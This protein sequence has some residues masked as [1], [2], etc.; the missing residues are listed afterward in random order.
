MFWCISLRKKSMTAVLLEKV[1][2]HLKF[3]MWRILNGSCR[4]CQYFPI[5]VLWNPRIPQNIVR[6]S[7]RNC[8]INKNLIPLRIQ[9]SISIPQEFL[10]SNWQYWSNCCTLP[11]VSLFCFSQLCSALSTFSDLYIFICKGSLGQKNYFQGSP[12]KKV[13]K[14]WSLQIY[15]LISRRILFVENSFN[16]LVILLICLSRICR[17]SFT[18]KETASRNK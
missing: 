12:Y 18:K 13:G 1:E 9:I 7:T 11:T 17:W 5:R 8:G 6:D 15:C 10:S 2:I 4:L 16:C 14:H 3:L